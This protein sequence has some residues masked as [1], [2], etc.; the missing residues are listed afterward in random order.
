VKT[1]AEV[2]AEHY[3]YNW[4]PDAESWECQCGHKL[5]ED[6]F[7]RDADPNHRAHQA[8]ALSAAGFGPVKVA[9]AEALRDAADILEKSA[10]NCVLMWGAEPMSALASASVSAI[11]HDAR[12][13]RRRAA[14]IEAPDGP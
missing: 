9:A 2:L 5:G 1:M 11:N 14:T 6:V 8:A 10:Q 12:R 3:E 7:R 13:L 4:E